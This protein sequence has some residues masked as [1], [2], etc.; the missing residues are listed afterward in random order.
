MNILIRGGGDLGSGVAFRLHNVG[1]NVVITEIEQPLVLRR[2]VSFGN[3]IYEGQMSVEGVQ[4]KYLENPD[5]IPKLLGNRVIP[6]LISSENFIF[7][8]YQPTIIVDARLL[9]RTVEYSIE[10]WP[11]I[12]GLGPGFKVS[13]NCHAIIETNRGH[14]LGRVIWE[15]EAI[16]D[17][18][19][20]GIVSNKNHERVLRAPDSGYIESKFAI[21]DIFK[22]DAIIGFVAGQPIIAPFDGCLRG[23]MHNGIYVKKGI[24]I[25]D[26]DP[27][28]DLNL[29][30]FISEKSLAI[31]GGVL[32]A[33]LRYNFLQ[34]NENF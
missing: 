20:P 3:A 31:A 12:I 9:K 22:K 16:A 33:I 5:D 32:E 8:S 27:R 21:G 14:Y 13:E 29:T 26:L 1:W 24:K 18:G 10:T 23:L 28:I 7:T 2:S 15:G 25:G 6:V 11:M 19:I 17:T 4:A 34:N 30:K